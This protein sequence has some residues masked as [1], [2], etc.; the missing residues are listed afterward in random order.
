[1]NLTNGNTG[2]EGGGIEFARGPG[3]GTLHL[4]DVHVYGNAAQWGGGIWIGMDAEVTGSGVRVYDNTA[5]TYG[6]GVRLFGGR[7]TLSD[8]NIYNNS[9]P[10]GG[11][12]HGTQEGG[13]SPALD[14]TSSADVFDNQALTGNG[15]GGGVYMHRPWRW[16]VRPGQHDQPR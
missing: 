13:H 16:R 4:N 3:T 11:G 6:G 7:L 1:L 15:L 9:A 10:L 2:Y 12:V 5:S 8:G 14:L